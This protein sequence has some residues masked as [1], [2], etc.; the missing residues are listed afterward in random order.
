M[1]K[2]TQELSNPIAGELKIGPK[3]FI[4]GV[5]S[6]VCQNDVLGVKSKVCQNDVVSMR[7]HFGAK[8]S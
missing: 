4:L 6:K 3:G 7:H 2:K 8:F 1:T 5:K